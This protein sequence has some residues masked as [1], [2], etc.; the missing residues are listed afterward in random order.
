M[1]LENEFYGKVQDGGN[2][3]NLADGDAVRVTVSI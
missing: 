3:G 1:E 2:N